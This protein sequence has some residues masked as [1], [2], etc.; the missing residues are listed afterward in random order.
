MSTPKQ[1]QKIGFLRKLIGLNEDLY[2]EMLADYGAASSKDL[3][4]KS[5]A[6]LL[7]RLKINAI[8]LGLYKPR[9]NHTFK[10]LK[11][12]NLGIREDMATPKQLRMVESMW[13]DVSVKEDETHRQAALNRFIKRIT[14]KQR[15]IFLTPEDIRKV[16]NAL[17][18]MKEEKCG[19]K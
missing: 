3:S 16:V 7:N 2:R 1:R 10:K 17:K 6:E 14:G 11:Y 18:K 5:A 8:K 19:Q 9:L 15:L 12:E 13:F 4:I